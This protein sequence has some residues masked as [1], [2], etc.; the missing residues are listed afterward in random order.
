V[1]IFFLSKNTANSMANL[2]KPPSAPSKKSGRSVSKRR[3]RN[4]DTLTH[5]VQTFS[6]TKYPEIKFGRGTKEG[7]SKVAIAFAKK[8]LSVATIF[9]RRSHR[10]TVKD[11]DVICAV[12]IIQSP[13]ALTDKENTFNINAKNPDFKRTNVKSSFPSQKRASVQKRP[14]AGAGAGKNMT[15]TVKL[16]LTQ[17]LSGSSISK[18]YPK[19]QLQ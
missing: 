16:S 11:R 5:Y 9:S 6:R 10:K 3:R 13:F 17:P 7:I 15:T 4:C 8:L 12:S 2:Q 1:L 14:G 19:L 18:R